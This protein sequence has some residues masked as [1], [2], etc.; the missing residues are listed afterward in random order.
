MTPI[1]FRRSRS[2]NLPET[3]SLRPGL[4]LF[5]LGLTSMLLAEVWESAR[6][7]ELSMHLEKSRSALA[8][9]EVRL[10][11]VKATLERHTTRAELT[12]VAS[13]MGL[14]PADAQQIVAL[15]A[16]YLEDGEATREPSTLPVLTWAE[17]AS[18]A[19]VPEATARDRRP[20]RTN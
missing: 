2:W 7:A 20:R 6:V 14:A 17:R 1:A 15:P 5:A 11:Y 16:S 10:E 13:A 12:P 18:R 9:A 8:Q 4:W 19:L 3:R